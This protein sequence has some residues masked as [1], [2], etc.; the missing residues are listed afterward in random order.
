MKWKA[1]EL[2][3]RRRQRAW[4]LCSEPR[5]GVWVAGMVEPALEDGAKL[6]VNNAKWTALHMPAG[7]NGETSFGP[8]LWTHLS[9]LDMTVRSRTG[10]MRLVECG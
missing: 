5:C 10:H 8:V 1:R 3:M 9:A 4:D 2:Q 7:L 6:Q